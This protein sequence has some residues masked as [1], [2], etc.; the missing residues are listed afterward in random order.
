MHLYRLLGYFVC[1]FLITLCNIVLPWSPRSKRPFCLT[2]CFRKTK[3]SFALLICCKENHFPYCTHLSDQVSLD[4]Q[5]F[6]LPGPCVCW[7]CS[8]GW[9][10]THVYP[11]TCPENYLS[12]NWWELTEVFLQFVWHF[13]INLQHHTGAFPNL[14]S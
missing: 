4:Y 14:S 6:L 7:W 12:Q 8:F 1:H 13:N 2:C 9:V 11:H 3:S 10:H 5:G